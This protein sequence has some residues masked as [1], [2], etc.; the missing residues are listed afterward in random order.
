MVLWRMVLWR[1]VLW[2]MALWKRALQER[3]RLSTSRY[4][5]S[6]QA[7]RS[8]LNGEGTGL[9]VAI[10]SSF[11]AIQV[12]GIWKKI[13][14]TCDI[15]RTKPSSRSNSVLPSKRSTRKRGK[16]RRRKTT[17]TTR[18]IRSR[19]LRTRWKNWQSQCQ[20]SGH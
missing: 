14:Q 16:V 13:Q 6:L 3:M 19:K 2:R 15:R 10:S 11:L 1:M 4:L 9:Q 7:Q 18:K 5:Q 12:I 20:S 8:A 17:T